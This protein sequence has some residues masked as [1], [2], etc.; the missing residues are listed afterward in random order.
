MRAS[1]GAGSGGI[2]ER[3]LDADCAIL[4]KGRPDLS[5]QPCIP[6][7]VPFGNEAADLFAVL[8]MQFLIELTDH[9]DEVCFPGCLDDCRRVGFAVSLRFVLPGLPQRGQV[10]GDL[11]RSASFPSSPTSACSLTGAFAGSLIHRRIVLVDV[12]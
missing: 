9:L 12:P 5:F 10:S 7:G 8:L 11:E 3:A 6:L 4:G 1:N 2:I